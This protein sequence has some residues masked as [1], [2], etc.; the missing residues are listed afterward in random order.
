V[1]LNL[2]AR[3]SGIA[4]L[5]ATF[6]EKAQ[7]YGARIYDT[8]KTTPLWRELEK[9]AVR[10][11]GGW[12]HRFDLSSAYFIKDN[13][14]DACEGMKHT[15]ERFFGKKRVRRP[16]IVEARSLEEARIAAEYPID[17]LLLDNMSPAQITR[18][19]E[20]IGAT[21]DMEISGRVHLGNVGHYARTGIPRISIGALTHSVKSLDIAL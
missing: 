1:A 2:L 14:I 6:V 21:C 15:L 8:R 19:M 12:N 17:L 20:K 9:Y 4:T 16:I 13:H 11:G 5:T 18:I 7:A 10:M 3:L